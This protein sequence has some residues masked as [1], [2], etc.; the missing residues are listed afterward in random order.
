VCDERVNPPH[1]VEAG[2]VS[3]LVGLRGAR[4]GE[5]GTWMITHAPDGSR[6]RAVRTRLLPAGMRMTV[7]GL[8]PADADAPA[9]APAPRTV[10]QELYGYYRERRPGDGSGPGIPVTATAGRRD[11]DGI[12][13]VHRD[14][15]GGGEPL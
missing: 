5:F 15:R 12:A 1:E 9:P 4:A 8:P 10:A 3:L 11:L 2:R 14:L 13:R 6:V 7:H